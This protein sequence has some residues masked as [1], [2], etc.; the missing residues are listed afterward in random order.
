MPRLMVEKFRRLV[1]YLPLAG[2]ALILILQDFVKGFLSAFTVGPA[3]AAMATSI[4]LLIWY[5]ESTVRRQEQASG[6]LSAAVDRM[7]AEQQKISEQVVPNF[8]QVSMG[9]GFRIAAGAV[10]RVRHLRIYAVT[11]QIQGRSL[12]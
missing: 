9:E 8:R 12:I 11:S 1:A 2:T 6:R 3:V 7:E 5:F 4:I 10:P